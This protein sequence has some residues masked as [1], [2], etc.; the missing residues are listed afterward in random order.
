MIRRSFWLFRGR[1][2]RQVCLLTLF[3]ASSLS[4]QEVI[5][6]AVKPLGEKAGRPL[7]LR[8]V[9]RIR[10]TGDKFYFSG[11]PGGYASLG[12]DAGG[13][14]YVQ[15]GRDQILTFTPAGGFIKNIV[16][17]GQGPGEVSQYFN[18]LVGNE[19]VFIIDHGQDRI[20]RLATDGRFV[21]QWRP[22]RG[23]NDLLGI[24]KSGLIFCRTNYPPIEKRTGKLIDVPHEILHV[25]FDGSEETKIHTY[26]VLEFLGQDYAASWA[27]FNAV[28]SDVG[29]YLF[30]NNTPEYEISLL[31]LDTG[32]IA[33]I[34]AR[35]YKRIEHTLRRGEAE[36]NKK[37]GF[38]RPYESDIRG[39]Y[40]FGDRLWVQTSTEDKEKGTLYDVYSFDGVYQDAFFL[41][42]NLVSIQR[43]NLLTWEKDEEGILS[44]V[45]YRPK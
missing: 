38:K 44:V 30:V 43:G 42:K 27:P 39:L 19:D 41:N 22:V 45:I 8:E 14:I 21:H 26:P 40:I 4:A 10:D 28:L 36:F 23:Y 24:H 25:S 29:K 9:L 37:Y 20:I 11:T 3:L 12:I 1:T 18:F 33:R 17:G 35:K 13:N 16:R 32:K 15:S 5:K 6:N 31:D 2:K 34:F 7:E